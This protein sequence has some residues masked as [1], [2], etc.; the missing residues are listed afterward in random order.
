M[1]VLGRRKTEGIWIDGRI[2]VKVVDVKRG[3]AKLGIEAPEEV[4]VIREELLTNAHPGAEP[5]PPFA[6]AR[7]GDQEQAI[8]EARTALEQ[9][10]VA[11]E[12]ASPFLPFNA[13]ADLAASKAIASIHDVL[14]TAQA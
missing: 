9:A 5:T 3:R 6:R 1:L 7:V 2:Y 12:K 4:P 11:L 14:R 13:T 8:Q 10:S